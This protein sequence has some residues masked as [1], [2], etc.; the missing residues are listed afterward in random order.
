[1][2]WLWFLLVKKVRVITTQRGFDLSLVLRQVCRIHSTKEPFVSFLWC[3]HEPT[4]ANTGWLDIFFSIL[5][6]SIFQ[7]FCRSTFQIEIWLC[8][9]GTFVRPVIFPLEIIVCIKR[10]IDTSFQLNHISERKLSSRG[11]FPIDV[12]K[13]MS[14]NDPL[15]NIWRDDGLQCFCPFSPFILY[16]PSFGVWQTMT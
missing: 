2:Q 3:K 7:T 15:F 9:S 1:M 4:L 12:V 16:E 6:R 5:Y 13:N 14:R 8:R 10:H 11:K